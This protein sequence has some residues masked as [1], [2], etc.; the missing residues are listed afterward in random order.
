MNKLIITKMLLFIVL[1]LSHD[2]IGQQKL[3]KVS[4]SIN[5]DKEA[6][7]DLNTSYCN[8]VFETWN[9]DVVEVEAYIESDKFWKILI[10]NI[11]LGIY[12]EAITKQR[13]E[14][15]L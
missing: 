4:Q 2:L 9:K 7:V 12:L 11:E 3:T 15:A 8:I 6:V 1:L 13:I 10:D 14:E 5:V